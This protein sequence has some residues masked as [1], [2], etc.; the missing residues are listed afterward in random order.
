MIQAA[1]ITKSLQGA[2]SRQEVY[3][4]MRGILDQLREG[5]GIYEAR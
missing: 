4:A 2:T 3:D 5:R 1:H